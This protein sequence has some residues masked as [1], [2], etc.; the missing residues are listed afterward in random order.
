[1]LDHR[2]DK[3]CAC[4]QWTPAVRACSC[5]QP[6]SLLYGETT[7]HTAD[8]VLIHAVHSLASVSLL[9]TCVS[10]YH[11]LLPESP[12]AH[13]TSLAAADFLVTS[14]SPY[15][16]SPSP[17]YTSPSSQ[18]STFLTL[19][20][21]KKR[22]KKEKKKRY[23]LTKPYIPFALCAPNDDVSHSE[24]GAGL[25]LRNN[26]GLASYKWYYLLILIKDFQDDTHEHVHMHMYTCMYTHAHTEGH[27]NLRVCQLLQVWT[28]NFHTVAMC[29]A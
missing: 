29:K 19:Y 7:S 23:H 14:T 4:C 28:I 5:G 17:A 18:L 9:S 6:A 22:K 24:R 10:S 1:M 27:A 26:L 3:K 25:L 12:R 8:V 13:T 2:G 16:N 15:N 11:S 21:Y 20:N